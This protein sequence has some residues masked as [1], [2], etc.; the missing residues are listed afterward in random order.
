VSRQPIPLSERKLDLVFL[1]FFVVNLLFITYLVDLEQVV[2]TD[3]ASFT[4]PLWPPAPLVK[5]IHWYGNTFDP[6]L[7][8][9]PPFWK[10]TVWLD[11]LLFGPYYVF[12]IHAF[13]LGRDWIRLPT[14]IYATMLFTNV[15]IIL[16]EEAWGANASPRLA[17]VAALNLP[18]LLMPVALIARV[19]PSE[20]PFTRDPGPPVHGT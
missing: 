16:S 18:W 7:I 12:A 1:G 19:W 6:L 3:P 9:R 20:H 13:R 4:Y 8:A 5:L 15:V 11:L 2:I 17:V 10:V 14:V